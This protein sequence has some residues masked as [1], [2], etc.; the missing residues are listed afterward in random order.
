MFEALKIISGGVCVSGHIRIAN[1]VT[2]KEEF[3][4]AHESPLSYLAINHDGSRIAT[5]SEKVFPTNNCSFVPDPPSLSTWT[6]RHSK[7]GTGEGK[8][9]TGKFNFGKNSAR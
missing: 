7:E 8:I 5:A 6:Y 3:V 1:L 2:G 4:A 9:L